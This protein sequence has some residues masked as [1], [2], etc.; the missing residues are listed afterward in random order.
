MSVLLV[1]VAVVVAWAFL[2][3]S[4]LFGCT[5][6][7]PRVVARFTADVAVAGAVGLIVLTAS[8][9]RRLVKGA[10]FRLNI[11]ALTAL[12]PLSRL[13]LV[14]LATVFFAVVVAAGCDHRCA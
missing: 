9:P 6:A 13:P 4:V 2:L 1:F 7:L 5:A 3:R 10:R 8:A 14:S 11:F 12:W